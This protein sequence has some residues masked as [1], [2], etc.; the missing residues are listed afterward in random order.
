[1]LQWTCGRQEDTGGAERVQAGGNLW[2]QLGAGM[3]G[4]GQTSA[5]SGRAL[6]CPGVGADARLAV[7]G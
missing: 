2:V 5:V 1:M 7:A 3:R 4:S 6:S